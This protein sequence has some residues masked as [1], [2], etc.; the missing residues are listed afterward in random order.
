MEI[1]EKKTLLRN[2]PLLDFTADYFKK[3]DFSRTLII[4]VQHLYSTTYNMF[5]KLFKMG[6]KPNN[7][8]IV[9]K[10]YSTDPDVF[11]QLKKMVSMFLLFP[12][13]LIAI[14]PMTSTLKKDRRF[15]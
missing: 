12:I 10:C 7:L 11:A 2:L 4:C 9:G 14:A 6:L 13:T 8:H 1:L 3:I 15:L 5:D